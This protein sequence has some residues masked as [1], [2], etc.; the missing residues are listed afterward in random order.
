MI[1]KFGLNFIV[2][3]HFFPFVQSNKLDV[4]RMFITGQEVENFS[5]NTPIKLMLGEF[6]KIILCNSCEKGHLESYCF[7]YSKGIGFVM[8][9]K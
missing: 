2:W 5:C 6:I 3:V 8:G 9:L 7:L 4:E 1:Y